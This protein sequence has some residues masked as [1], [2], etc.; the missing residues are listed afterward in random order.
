MEKEDIEMIKDS[1]NKMIKQIVNTC[2]SWVVEG[3][4]GLLRFV[5][6]ID[7]EEISAHYGAAHAAVSF[8]L[9]GEKT[10][11][12]ELLN[13]GYELLASILK[14]WKSSMKLPAFH[15]DFNN[16]ALCVA[17]EYFDKNNKKE[18]YANKIKEL[19]LSTPDSNNPTINWF[20]MRWYVN[21][22]RYKWTSDEKFKLA[23]DKCSTDIRAA[24]YKDGFIDDRLPIGLSFN[25]QY[26]VATVAVLQYLR[27]NG[28]NIDISVELGA[29]LNAVAPDGD[30]NYFGRGTNQIFAWG[31]WVYLLSSAGKKEQVKI[32]LNFL[33][34][35]LPVML[36]NNNMMLNDWP[37]EEKYMWWDYHYCSVYTAHLLFWLIMA[38]EQ[39]DKFPL[40]ETIIAPGD[41]GVKVYRDNDFFV[42]TFDGRKEYLAEKGPCVVALWTKSC[43]MVIKGTFGP[44]QGAF[45][46]KYSP[47]DVTIRNYCGLYK[48]ELNKDFSKNRYLHKALP[49]LESKS[50]EMIT[51][52]FAPLR[53]NVHKD[54]ISIVWKIKES[55]KMVLSI[56]CLKQPA[57]LIV[58]IDEKKVRVMTTSMI[59][60]QY[61]WLRLLQSDLIKGNNWEVRFRR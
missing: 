53:I 61:T 11:N 8:I 52:V 21:L 41:S 18:K 38:E 23:C 47:V 36:K 6:P 31:L 14:R 13:L 49:N 57:D 33:Q 22:I 42:V 29:L 10:G 59:R 32:A 3:E 17:W 20:P 39:M 25:L 35:K 58:N 56:P 26:D 40:T 19:V 55:K 46:N 5:D 60:N 16:F 54:D 44:W 43:G 1:I 28:E 51:P 45:G 4:D 12:D 30:I 48:V 9:Y 15:N 27:S 37:G 50:H 2:E 7:G 34:E 24:T